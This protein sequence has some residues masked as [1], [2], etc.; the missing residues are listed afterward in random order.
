MKKYRGATIA[1][2]LFLFFLGEM[3][4]WN[5]THSWVAFFGAWVAALHFDFDE[6]YET[7]NK[8]SQSPKK[9]VHKRYTKGT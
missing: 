5:E 8:P 2:N 4:V 6:I 9:E 3:I 1:V 7:L